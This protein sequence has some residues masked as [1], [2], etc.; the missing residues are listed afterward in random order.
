MKAILKVTFGCVLIV[1]IGLTIAGLTA[2]LSPKPTANT[3]GDYL[4]V[5]EVSI[6]YT[7]QGQGQ[8]IVLIHGLPGSIE[9]W[10]AITES[11]A[12]R[13]RVTV[14]DRPGHG[15]SEYKAEL[16]NLEG[17]TDIV[18][19]L[20][21]KLKLDN[22]IVV[23]HSYGGA[24]AASMA[25]RNPENIGGFVSI[26]GIIVKD[27]IEGIFQILNIPGLGPGLALIANQIIGPKMMEVGVP[28]AF[29]PNNDVI[30]ENYIES[31]A[32]M[33]LTVKNGLAATGEEVTMPTDLEAVDLA[34]IK[35]PFS[36]LHGDNDLS[37]PLHN[38]ERF[39]K[40]IQGSSLQVLKQTGHFIQYAH[41]A[42]VIKA[43]DQMALIVN[44]E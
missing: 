33:W 41:P 44:N 29:Y 7:Q 1:V 40:N 42:E 9:D 31:R 32:P 3:P 8:D 38:A 10:E 35:H 43:I 6:R 25:S 19:A 20:I 30:P 12:K 26:G 15:Y 11:L 16:A 4:Q 27:H 14:F 36:I 39:H 21:A 17:N 18:F 34:S 28:R 24:I 5:K 37:V 13:Y 23:G 22:P 2:D